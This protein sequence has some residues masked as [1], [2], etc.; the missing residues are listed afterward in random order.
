M[1]LWLAQMSA[2]D[3]TLLSPTPYTVRLMTSLLVPHTKAF[4]LDASGVLVF[5]VRSN[6]GPMHLYYRVLMRLVLVR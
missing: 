4:L 1:Q 5:S 6:V 3:G 2:V